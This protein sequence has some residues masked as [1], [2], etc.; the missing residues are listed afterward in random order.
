MRSKGKGKGKKKAVVNKEEN[1]E[2]WCFVCKD[3]GDLIICDHACVFS[4]FL[5]PPLLT[6]V[7]ICCLEILHSVGIL[8]LDWGYCFFVVFCLFLCYVF[9]FL[10]FY[11]FFLFFNLFTISDLILFISHSTI[12]GYIFQFA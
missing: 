2:S 8:P 10:F 11:L 1:A 7:F 9:L 12:E 5:F 3:G 4:Q 6:F